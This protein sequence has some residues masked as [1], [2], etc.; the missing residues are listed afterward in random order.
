MN[1]KQCTPRSEA[2]E[3]ARL[4][5]LNRYHI[6]DTPREQEFDDFTR[7]AAYIFNTP[8]AVI[9]LID[10]DRQWFKSEIG[11][12]VRETPL[13][14]SICRHAILQSEFF[15]VPDTTQD[16]RF[17][18]NPLVT[19]NP[20]L[21]F[22]AGALLKSSEDLPLG[23]LCVLDIQPREIPE[24]KFSRGNGHKNRKLKQLGGEKVF[25]S[26]VNRES[27]RKDRLLPCALCDLLVSTALFG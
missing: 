21:R 4:A 9:N 1:D 17:K 22:Y 19:G 2:E 20:H 7:L 5:A 27:R 18:H 13:D 25:T 14:T 24:P 3:S 26:R 10:H 23:T 11:L 16:E 12:G 6:L 15:I 8:I